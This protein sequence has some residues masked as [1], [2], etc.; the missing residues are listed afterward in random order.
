M[1]RH[2]AQQLTQKLAPH[3]NAYIRG[4]DVQIT[5]RPISP[6]NS[7]ASRCLLLASTSPFFP[8]PI[9]LAIRKTPGD[10]GRSFHSTTPPLSPSSNGHGFTYRISASYSDKA[11][12]FDSNKNLFNYN[13][14]IRFQQSS[15]SNPDKSKEPES[16]EDAFF[17]SKIGNT[18]DVAFG[19]ADGVGGYRDSGIDPKD[20]SHG[21]CNYMASTAYNYPAQS[22]S[23]SDKVVAPSVLRPKELMQS[24]YLGVCSDPKINGGGST[25]C[26]GTGRKDGSMEIANLGDSGFLHFRLGAVHAASKPQTHRFNMPFQLSSIP[27][28]IA[29]QMALFGG[30]LPFA[31]LP[32]DSDVYNLDMQH[33]DVVVLA[34]DG[35]WDNLSASDTLAIVTRYMSSLGAWTTPDREH[36]V[37]VSS[38]IMGLTGAEMSKSG[39]NSLQALLAI[40]IAREAKVASQ[41]P[42][43]DGP[44]AKEVQRLYPRDNWHGG[45]PDDIVVVVVVALKE[46]GEAKSKL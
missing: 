11:K 23:R 43:R 40:S 35:V 36:G 7:R 15:P 33:G 14:F 13:P 5:T 25:A 31:D 42:K 22:N 3:S 39:H 41:N 1:L 28:K 30:K 38:K 32:A 17:V 2:E 24:G 37:E 12:N 9:R 29:H 27:A 16:G 6:F 46:E 4:S 26:V 10:S 8:P 18:G 20:F 44:F 45:K 21:L 34:S 19:V